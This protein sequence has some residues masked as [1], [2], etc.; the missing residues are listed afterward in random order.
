VVRD[1]ADT[2][3]DDRLVEHVYTIRNGLIAAMDVYHDGQLASAPRATAPKP[4]LSS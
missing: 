1:R 2:I 4:E 3:L